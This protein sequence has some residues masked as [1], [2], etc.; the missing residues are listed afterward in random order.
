MTSLSNN[1]LRSSDAETPQG[2]ADRRVHE[3]AFRVWNSGLTSPSNDD[4]QI[5]ER[6]LE[7]RLESD[8]AERGHPAGSTGVSFLQEGL[9]DVDLFLTQPLLGVCWLPFALPVDQNETKKSL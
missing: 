2:R 5:G 8:G 3:S 6:G 4:W 7:P 1:T 9:Q